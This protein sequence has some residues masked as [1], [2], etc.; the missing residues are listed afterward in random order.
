VM[1]PLHDIV[2]LD[3]SMTITEAIKKISQQ[4]YSR[5][6]VYKDEPSNIIGMIHIKDLFSISHTQHH[7]TTLA[8]FIR[9]HLKV[10]E[11]D[12]VL[13]IFHLFRKGKPRFAIV[14]VGK[15]AIGFL[16]LD[17]LLQSIIGEIKDEF[18]ITQEDWIKL[19]DGTY[20]IKGSASVFTLETLLG[21][22]LTQVESNTVTGLILDKYQNFPHEGEKIEFDRFTLEIIKV[23]GSR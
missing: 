23:K 6:P 16:T 1:R 7:N 3:I 21:I 15:R 2:V 11:S 22:E 10:S 18:H 8:R 17:D 13:E 19:D 9:P 14:F 20:I 4:R 5:Y 12:P